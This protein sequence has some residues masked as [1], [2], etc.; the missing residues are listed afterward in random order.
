M[1]ITNKKKPL[2]ICKT[3]TLRTNQ[4]FVQDNYKSLLQ[5]TKRRFERLTSIAKKRHPNTFS[6]V[7]A[8]H[9][10]RQPPHHSLQQQQYQLQMQQKQAQHDAFMARF[11]NSAATGGNTSLSG[12]LLSNTVANAANAV[13]VACK[14]QQQ[15]Q[16]QQHQHQNVLID[17]TI[18]FKT[19]RYLVEL[20]ILKEKQA[21][22]PPAP[23]QP[24]VQTTQPSILGVT[25][26]GATVVATTT[27]STT[28]PGGIQQTTNVVPV[29]VPVQVVET[30]SS[31]SASA[32]GSAASAAAQPQQ[33]T[34]QVQVLHPQQHNLEQSKQIIQNMQN[35]LHQQQQMQQQAVNVTLKLFF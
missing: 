23:S 20:K 30:T 11:A 13:A 26:S 19:P 32:V 17:A 22:L 12:Q 9:H 8:S 5:T 29:I 21:K 15:Q 10:T 2:N 28:I 33:A 1:I 6:Y 31:T 14:Q 3:K 7:P 18:G 27:T 24:P 16:Q 25:A 4:L 35:K 34:V